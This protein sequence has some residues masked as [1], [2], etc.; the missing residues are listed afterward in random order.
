[1]EAVM[2]DS[3]RSGARLLGESVRAQKRSV[4]V[5]GGNAHTA[6]VRL[7]FEGNA[8]VIVAAVALPGD[9]STLATI[10]AVCGEAHMREVPA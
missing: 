10:L 7:G 9:V 6:A 8:V 5:I 3:T 2:R 1:M 4:V